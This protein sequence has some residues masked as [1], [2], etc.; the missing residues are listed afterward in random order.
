MEVIFTPDATRAEVEGLYPAAQYPGATIESLANP[1]QR[2]ATPA[3]ET[4]LRTLIKSV[5]DRDGWEAADREEAVAVALAD[6]ADALA[7]WRALVAGAP[8]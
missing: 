6:P 5:A 2:P 7:C 8:W 3:E 1:S 4:E